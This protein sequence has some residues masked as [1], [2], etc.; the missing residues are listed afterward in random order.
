MMKTTTVILLG[1]LSASRLWASDLPPLVLPSGVGVNIHFA[2]GH[3]RDL[4]LIA[5]AG[6]K[7]IRMDFE[8]GSIE[9]KKGE[10]DWSAYDELTDNLERRGIR[11]LYILDYSNGLYED[12]VVS[13]DPISG[14]E[15]RDIASPQK[16]ESIAAFAGWAAAAAKHFQ[17]RHVVWEIWNEPNLG[18]WKPKPDPQQYATLALATCRAM[19]AADPQATIIA[20]GSSGFPWQFIETFLASGALEYFD[21]VS[22]HPYRNYSKSPETASEEYLK[23]RGFIE[24]YA[25]PAQKNLPIIC[26]EWGYATHTKGV[27][28]ETQAAFIARQQLADLLQNVPISIWYDWKNDGTNPGSNENNFGTVREDL[29]IKPS[30]TAMQTLTRQLSGF[31]ISR[32][33]RTDSAEDFVLLLLNDGGEQK[34]VAWTVG[35]PHR[36]SVD[37]GIAAAN[38]SAVDG[39]GQPLSIKDAS[40]SA[41]AIDLQIAPQYLTLK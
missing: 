22:V 36:I 2:R 20:P 34:L 12:A 16:S 9:R 32:R 41:L 18:F 40:G 21:A 3:E 10:F 6:F 4:D 19:R 23:L 38:V 26:S 29:S 35:T 17:G 7:L 28:L 1:L 11:P 27:S 31:H 24:R 5:A 14:K 37:A 30:Y 39:Q 25:P 33:M 15:Q 13:K 8:W